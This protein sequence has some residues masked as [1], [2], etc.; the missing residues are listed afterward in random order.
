[1][2][3]YEK[4]NLRNVCFLGSGGSGKTSLLETLFYNAGVITRLGKV[5]EGNTISD[6][7][8]EEIDR[9]SSLYLTLASLEYKDKKINFLDTPGYADFIG[10]VYAAMNVCET[11][12]FVLDSSVGLDLTLESL[13]E[14]ATT[15]GLVP[16]IYINKLDKEEIN[17]WHFIEEIKKK[18]TPQAQPFYLPYGEAVNFSGVVDLLNKKLLKFSE[19]KTETL[20]IPSE[21]EDLVEKKHA[22]LIETIASEDEVL[23]EKYLNGE[24]IKLN[25]LKVTLEKAIRE[26]K[27]VPLFC[28]STIKNI[29]PHVLLDF[30]IDYF[31]KPRIEEKNSL[32]VLIFKTFLEPHTGKIS[33]LKVHSG[34]LA[35]GTDVYNSNRRIRERAGQLCVVQGKKRIDVPN[36]S[37]GDLGC[38]AKLKESLTN[39]TLCNE[40]EVITLKPIVFPQASMDLAIYPKTSGEEEKIA[41]ALSVVVQEDPTIKWHYNTETKETVVYGIGETQ[42]E[43]MINR[44]KERYNVGVELRRPRVPYKETI[45]IKSEVQGKYKRQSGGRGQYGDCWLRLEPLERGKGYEFIDAIREGRI[46]KNYIPSIEKGVKQA[47]EEGIIA[48]YPVVDIKITLYDGSYHEVDSSDIAFKIAGAMALKKGVEQG[49]PIIL[50]PIVNVEITIPEEYL[51]A[52]VGDLNAR[53]GRVL[54]T[55]AQGRKQIVKAQVPFTEMYKYAAQL[56]SLSKGS[57]KFQMN[58]SHYE[59][60]PQ[61]VTQKLIEEYQKIKHGE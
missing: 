20:E 8:P 22:E 25:E 39:D 45:K 4:E 37:A 16:V 55:E 58:L 42:L 2:K 56:R 33:Y 61:P 43:V 47:M 18:L 29:G 30:I 13:W 57:G 11:A 51:G 24:E 17:F 38:V 35:Q 3:T 53:R 41:N 14:E 36:L 10:E 7:T 49:K 5:G 26:R 54:G 52:V 1:M 50:E 15:K 46:P 28:G 31:P 23:I 6:F 44:I 59:E 60:A 27:I 12:I 34:T 9:K 32:S 21:L 40:K 48:G 19:T